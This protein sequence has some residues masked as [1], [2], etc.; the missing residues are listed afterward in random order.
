MRNIPSLL[1]YKA[2]KALE[3]KI[4]DALLKNGSF[5]AYDI[6]PGEKTIRLGFY[7]LKAFFLTPKDN[8]LL[9]ILWKL[10]GY[11]FTETTVSFF[12]TEAGP[13]RTGKSLW[14]SG[15]IQTGACRHRRC[16]ENL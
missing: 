7:S 8:F 15:Q 2:I 14:R 5:S 4:I 16:L 6:V 11:K 3:R 13:I 1:I 9:W 12:I 10:Y